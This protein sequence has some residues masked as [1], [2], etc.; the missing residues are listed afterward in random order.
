MKRQTYVTTGILVVGI[1]LAAV[2]IAIVSG[3]AIFGQ[4][5]TTAPLSTANTVPTLAES[6]Q[7]IRIDPVADK[8]TGDLLIVSGST[9]LPAGTTVMVS[10]GNTGTNAD[11]RTG[12]NGVNR[13][14]SPL[15]TA[16]MK[17]GTKTITVNNMVGDPAKGDYK[18]GTVKTTA[19]FTLK[20]SDLTADAPVQATITERDYIRINAIGDRKVGEQFLITGTTSLPAGTTLIWEVMPYTG[21]QPT[22]LDMN[23]KGIMANNPVTKGDGSSNR[24]SLAADLSLM[25]PGECIV[26]VGEMKG[27]MT[28]QDIWLGDLVGSARF[29]V[30]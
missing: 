23:A 22:G 3:D 10:A 26:I 19:T 28:K 16:G 7:Y 8:A 5:G 12:S 25:E 30:T 1:I 15:D 9:N 21:T 29:R 27:D 14:S 6:G 11:V 13:F 17:P 2:C 20:G 24:I 18:P 4:P